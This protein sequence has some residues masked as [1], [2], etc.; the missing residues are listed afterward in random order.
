[1][2]HFVKINHEGK[3]VNFR[4]VQVEYYS[5]C[6]VQE[7][8]PA[9]EISFNILSKNTAFAFELGIELHQKNGEM[10]F[11]LPITSLCWMSEEQQ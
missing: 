2:R 10:W 7:D 3:K 1:M 9:I 11:T 6:D 4:D 5:A 8:T